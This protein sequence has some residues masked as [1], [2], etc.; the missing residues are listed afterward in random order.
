MSRSS[1]R[2]SLQN[3]DS[4]SLTHDSS[5][6]SVSSAARHGT[7]RLT[8]PLAR[9]V[10]LGVA[11]VDDSGWP[12]DPTNDAAS[13][14]GHGKFLKPGRRPTWSLTNPRI[15]GVAV[16]SR[17][18]RGAADLQTCASSLVVVP[19][20]SRIGGGRCASG[21]QSGVR[22]AKKPTTSIESRPPPHVN[23]RNPCGSW[24]S[25]CPHAT[26]DTQL[27][28]KKRE[29]EAG[30][31]QRPAVDGESELLSKFYGVPDSSIGV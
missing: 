15:V 17:G 26:S 7:G 4:C 21:P 25:L 16:L 23:T 27:N 19:W 3:K 22:G 29:D 18:Q 8:S 31:A 1:Q 5:I 14:V 12:A 10:G 2:D 24:R 13:R 6:H 30:G 28:V 20:T 11:C 9:G